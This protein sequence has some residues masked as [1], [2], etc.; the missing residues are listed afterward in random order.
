MLHVWSQGAHGN[1]YPIQTLLFDYRKACNLIDRGIL[2]RH[3]CLLD[4]PVSIIN[5]IIDFLSQRS[6]RIIL[7]EGCVSGWGEVLSGVPKG[8]KLG[9]WLFLIMINDLALN[10]TF[11]WKYLDYTTGSE[12][13]GKEEKR[14][15]Q[16]IADDVKDWS[17]RN[18][19]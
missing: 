7:S 10:N 18:K 13:I 1:E 14:N 9:S 2:V 4:F 17:C 8:T 11:L 16:A 3:L 15:A 19:V 6:Q 12:F 5:W